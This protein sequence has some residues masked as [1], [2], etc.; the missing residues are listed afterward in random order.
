MSTHRVDVV[1]LGPVVKHPNADTLGLVTIKG[2]T[3]IVRLT[4]FKEGDLAVYIEPDYVVPDWPE[5]A[6]LKGKN[7]IKTMRLRQVWSQGL[8]IPVPAVLGDVKP[9]DD[10]MERLS[11]VRYESPIDSAGDAER[12]CDV[13]A[14]LPKYD[15]ENWRGGTADPPAGSGRKWKDLF[16]A[17]E[18]VYVTEKIHGANARYAFR[19]GRMWCGSRTQWKKGPGGLWWMAL[20]QQP[21]IE[22]W[23]RKYPEL[24]LFG[25]VYGQVQDLR[26]DSKPGQVYFRAFDV[27]LRDGSWVA[28]CDMRTYFD[29]PVTQCVPFVYEGPYDAA[30]IEELSMMDSTLAKHLAE[31]IV[32]KPAVERTDIEL[33]R[34]VLKI[35]SNRYM[36]RA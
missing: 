36:E 8:L 2:Y 25:E 10:V 23:C 1:Q 22:A 24:V 32:I 34:V 12:P 26:Y 13:L 4:D 3:C 17:G 29:D 21:W 28:A 16:V 15:V 33:G 11:I 5:F 35:V 6:F 30:K 20:E 19:E 27:A 9:G 18:I 31:G 7:R 14:H